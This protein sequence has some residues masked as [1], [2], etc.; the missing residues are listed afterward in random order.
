MFAFVH[1][2]HVLDMYSVVVY[3][4]FVFGFRICTTTLGTNLISL[5]TNAGTVSATWLCTFGIIPLPGGF[6]VNVLLEVQTSL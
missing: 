1:Q 4:L 5:V 6:T 2:S 3:Y